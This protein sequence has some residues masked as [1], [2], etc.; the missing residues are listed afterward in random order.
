[1]ALRR[2][3]A[4]A[5]SASLVTQLV[6][7]VLDALELLQHFLLIGRRLGQA[8]AGADHGQAD[9]SP[10]GAGAPPIRTAPLNGHR[11]LQ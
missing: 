6:H 8:D 5:P 11:I 3:S 1:M 10:G 4:W 7:H 9:Q 2:A